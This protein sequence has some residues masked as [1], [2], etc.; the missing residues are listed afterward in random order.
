MYGNISDTTQIAKREIKDLPTKACSP[1]S[2]PP[3]RYGFEKGE[4]HVIP[5]K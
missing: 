5:E 3:L 2:K 4:A 1:I